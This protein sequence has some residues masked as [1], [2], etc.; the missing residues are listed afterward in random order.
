MDFRLTERHIT[1][2][3]FLLV[4]ALAYFAALS[5]NDIVARSLAPVPAAL[6]GERALAHE[7]PAVHPRAYYEAIVKR[8]IFNLV[9][10]PEAAAPVVNID[11][12][13]KLLGTSELTLK[14]PF[15]VLEDQSGIQSLY[16]LGD[17]VPGAGKLVA[18]EK[19]RVVIDHGG[20]RVAIE[21]PQE[22]MLGV[23]PSQVPVAGPSGE[24]NDEAAAQVE[25]DVEETGPNRYAINRKQLQDAL[26][27]PAQLFTQVRAMPIS[28][29][30][31]RQAGFNLSEIEP[32]SV[33]D[34]MGLQDGDL[35]TAVNGQ[36]II[37]PAQA[38]TMLGGLQTMPSVDLNIIRDS[39]PV[40]LHYDIR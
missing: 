27:N 37:S 28:V 19:N 23:E 10:Q 24:D 6:R 15:A 8:D 33:F 36:P 3:N 12:H 35:V 22:P 29:G 39:R 9:P 14:K 5:V 26:R 30:P 16:R 18:V 31:G 20:R 21:I 40:R 2:L 1:A 38:I 25:I 13:L 32:G 34:D 7:G 17:D 11:L 4:A